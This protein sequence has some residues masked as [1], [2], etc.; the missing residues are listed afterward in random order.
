[1][2]PGI[3]EETVEEIKIENNQKTNEESKKVSKE[4]K[5]TEEIKAP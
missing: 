3:Y 4:Q 5:K 2:P 1:M